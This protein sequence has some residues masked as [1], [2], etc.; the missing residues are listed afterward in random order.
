MLDTLRDYYTA[1]DLMV[2]AI[3]ATLIFKLWRKVVPSQ[4][5]ALEAMYDTLNIK[6]PYFYGHSRRVALICSA[7]CEHLAVGGSERKEVLS[8]AHLHDIGKLFIDEEI[9]NR[10]GKLTEDEWKMVRLHPLKGAVMAEKFKISPTICNTILQHHENLDGTGYPLNLKGDEITLGARILRVA[11][12]IDAMAMPRPY[13]LALSFEHIVQ[14][15]KDKSGAWYDEGI[16]KSI[17]NGLSQRIRL[18]ILNNY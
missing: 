11:D 2:K 12:S 5:L 9:L 16:V 8:S 3:F 4:E 15:L 14:E 18:I 6:S 7:V 10:D 1:F 17:T 13:R